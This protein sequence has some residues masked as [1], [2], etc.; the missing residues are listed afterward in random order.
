M[1]G[2]AFA[3]V[4]PVFSSGVLMAMSAGEMAADATDVWLDNPARGNAMARRHERK[5]VAAMDR[6]AWL[7]Y[8][9]NTPAMRAMFMSPSNALGMR[10]G[11]VS[12]LAGNLQRDARK[13]VSVLAFKA[14]YYGFS[15]AF[16]LRAWNARPGSMRPSTPSPQT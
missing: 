4:D 15:A 6:I 7:I 13:V 14:A 1:I 12:L 8:R 16:R 5:L 3:F 10:D 2:D 11:L 9:I